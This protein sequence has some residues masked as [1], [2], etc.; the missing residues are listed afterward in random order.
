[1]VGRLRL[2]GERPLYLASVLQGEYLR[3]TTEKRK[4]GAAVHREKR[5]AQQCRDVEIERASE[6]CK[7]HLLAARQR[8]HTLHVH[9]GNTI[10]F[11]A[12]DS[13]RSRPKNVFYQRLSERR[14]VSSL[15]LRNKVFRV[16]NQKNL[17]NIAPIAPVII[18]CCTSMLVCFIPG[19]QDDD[20]RYNAFESRL[21]GVFAICTGVSPPPPL[22]LRHPRPFAQLTKQNAEF[23]I[24]HLCRAE[25]RRVK[26]VV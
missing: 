1:M 11:M 19:F 2:R 14:V 8:E 6:V 26:K 24:R 13:R 17:Q 7:L 25:V 9:F 12:R 18:S 4:N 15:L 3:R 5:R 16:S 20:I 21:C 22:L 23:Q 10:S